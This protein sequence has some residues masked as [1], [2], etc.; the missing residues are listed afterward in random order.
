MNN[1]LLQGATCYLSGP[2]DFV[3]DRT[4]ERTTGWRNRVTQFL[5]DHGCRA[6]DPWY[7]P[8]VRNLGRYGEETDGSIGSRD[9]W[10]FSPTKEAAR[11]RYRL[12]REFWPVMH[13]D[14]RMVDLS[15]FVIATCP[16]NLY[17]VGTPHEIVVAR[18]QRKP[19]LLVSPP[20]RHVAWNELKHEAGRLGDF[21]DLID[22]VERELRVKPNPTGTPSAWYMSLIDSESFFDGFGFG[23]Y[24]ERYGWRETSLDQSESESPPVRPLL[25][26][27]ESLAEGQTPKRWNGVEYRQNDDWLLLE[28]KA[29]DSTRE[30]VERGS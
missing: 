17:S 29:T 1:N 24:R 21:G 2:M 23:Q 4:I 13:I 28:R 12:A 26:F 16:T 27:L 6:F 3:T 25:A 5:E 18:Q 20:I 11:I 22:E 19:V 8:A 15:D 14:L 7:K 30:E 10:T 9:A